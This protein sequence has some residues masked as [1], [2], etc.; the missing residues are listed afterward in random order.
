MLASLE[1]GIEVL[2]YLSMKKSAAVSEIAAV[3]SVDKSTASRILSTLAHH[4]L[5]A[6]NEE[7]G[8]YSL[9]VGA[10][11]FSYRATE[12]HKIIR[13]ARPVMQRVTE[14]TGESSHLCA[15]FKKNIYII[16]MIKSHKNK[17]RK[18]TTFPG[19]AEP[20]HCSAVGK[21]M[22][23]FLPQEEAKDILQ[24]KEMI[25]FTKKTVRSE[26][27]LISQFQ[28]IR[29]S[30][31]ALDNEEFE[32]GVFCMAVPIFNGSGSSVFSIG[33]SG[34]QDIMNLGVFNRNLTVLKDA[35]EEITARYN[36]IKD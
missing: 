16:D 9:S 27:E 1:R 21:C 23:A 22:L 31:Y 10:L 6:K 20:L 13:A 24:G 12:N 7:N 19:M 25:A 26:E 15:L 36:S 5:V 33:L 14:K 28:S 32:T 29:S 3:F 2:E 8:R 17:Y 11:L 18:D 34:G 4:N 30:G 35:S